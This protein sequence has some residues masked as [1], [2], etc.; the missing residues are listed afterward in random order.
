LKEDSSERHRSAEAVLFRAFGITTNIGQSED[1]W[2]TLAIVGPYVDGDNGPPT[3]NGISRAERIFSEQAELAR[4]QFERKADPFAP[5]QVYYAAR[6]LNREIPAWVMARIDVVAEAIACSLRQKVKFDRSDIAQALSFTTK[7]GPT[8][9]ANAARDQALAGRVFVRVEAGEPVK[10]AISEVSKNSS[11]SQSTVERAWR[12]H[13]RRRPR[14]V[15]IAAGA[16]IRQKP[17]KPQ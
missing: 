14:L 10:V 11:V 12:A 2:E 5:W 15:H 4:E 9:G 3:S 6:A 13:K 16:V 17:L 7:R 1:P 8:P